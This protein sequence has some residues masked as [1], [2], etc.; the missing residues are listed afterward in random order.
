MN[1]VKLGAVNLAKMKDIYPNI[2]QQS[3]TILKE[4]IES[5]QDLIKV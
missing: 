2:K 5:L 1:I 3:L 4:V